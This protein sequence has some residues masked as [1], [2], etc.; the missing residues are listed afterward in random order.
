MEPKCSSVGLTNKVTL[1]S[2]GQTNKLFI[3]HV[4]K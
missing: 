3:Q 4:K 1:Q 2:N